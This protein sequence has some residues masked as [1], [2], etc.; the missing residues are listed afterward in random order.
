MWIYVYVFEKCWNRYLKNMAHNPANH[1]DG[2][3]KI[4]F[5]MY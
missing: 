2:G 5:M 1:A 3:E 4:P